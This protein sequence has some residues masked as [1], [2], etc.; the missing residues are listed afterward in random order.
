MRKSSSAASGRRPALYSA[1]NSHRRSD[2]DLG[3]PDRS[4]WRRP[5]A[6]SWRGRLS[7]RRVPAASAQA[8]AQTGHP[9]ERGRHPRGRHGLVGHRAVWQR[10]RH[11]E[12]RRARRARRAIHAVLRDAA[13]LADA[14]EPAHRPLFAPGG[15]GPSRQRDPPRVDRHDRTTQRPVRHDGRSAPRRGLLHRDVRQVA[16]RPG[17]RHAAVGARL[18][19]HR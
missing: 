1:P 4:G 18:R 12:S 19:T 17:Q 2:G 5:C 13:L 16:S 10:D 6:R 15:H 8:A 14:R 3:A 9:P 7:S 11:A